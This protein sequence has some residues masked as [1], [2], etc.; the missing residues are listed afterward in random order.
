VAITYYTDEDL[1]YDLGAAFRS[2]GND[3]ETVKDHRTFGW[4]DARQLFLA[5]DLGRTM[6]T[7][8]KKDFILLHEALALWHRRWAVSQPLRHHGIIIV[9]PMD[10]ADIVSIV[11][12]F[13]A[14]RN[15]LD[16]QCFLYDK[17]TGWKEIV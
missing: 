2:E 4:S 6:I 12:D 1:Q 3:A 14:G 5:V 13:T 15:S 17:R 8:N 11:I 9:P 16:N 7:S 10:I